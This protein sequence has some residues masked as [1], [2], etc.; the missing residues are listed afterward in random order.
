MDGR[1]YRADAALSRGLEPVVS[2]VEAATAQETGKRTGGSFVINEFKQ[3]VKT[4]YLGRGRGGQSRYKHLL[5]GSFP[6]FHAVFRIGIEQVSSGS[7]TGLSFG[8]RWAPRPGIGIRYH[9]RGN[10]LY[11][12][13]LTTDGRESQIGIRQHFDVDCSYLIELARKAKNNRGGRIYVNEHGFAVGPNKDDNWDYV[14]I[15]QIDYDHWITPEMA[16]NPLR[17]I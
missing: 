17:H 9:L 7:A 10:D 16:S 3:V 14:F 15:Q 11:M 2:A 8:D 12:D 1:E 13:H 4:V 5:L 6:E